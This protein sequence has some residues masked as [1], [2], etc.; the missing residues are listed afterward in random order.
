[1]QTEKPRI[2]IHFSKQNNGWIFYSLRDE[3]VAVWFPDEG[4]FAYAA[5]YYSKEIQRSLT[6]DR[7]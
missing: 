2:T 3:L 7:G 4:K 6:L 1:M 5:K